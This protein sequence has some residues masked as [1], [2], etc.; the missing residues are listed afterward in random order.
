MKASWQP[1][2]AL[3]NADIALFNAQAQSAEKG[4]VRAVSAMSSQ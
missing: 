4:F 1:D 3:I 2:D